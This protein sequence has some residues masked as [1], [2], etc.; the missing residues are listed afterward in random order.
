[1]D[2]ESA[3]RPETQDN[4]VE[5]AASVEGDSLLPHIAQNKSGRRSAVPDETAATES[6][7]LS[8]RKRKLIVSAGVKLTPCWSELLWL[9]RRASR[10]RPRRAPPDAGWAT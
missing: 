8:Q 7:A 10:S 9:D 2:D 4:L 3:L 1:M 5:I 6:S